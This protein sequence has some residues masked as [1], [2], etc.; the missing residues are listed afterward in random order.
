MIK[1]SDHQW[2]TTIFQQLNLG[3]YLS[4]SM[5]GNFQQLPNSHVIAYFLEVNNF[6]ELKFSNFLIVDNFPHLGGRQFSIVG[7][8]HGHPDH[9]YGTKRKRA[10]HH[11]KKQ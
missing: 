10:R 6:Q 1:T 8:K 9:A 3:T 2:S 7:N 11:T 4:F 5:V